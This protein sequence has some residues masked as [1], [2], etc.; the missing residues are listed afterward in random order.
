MSKNNV[1]GFFDREGEEGRKYR[2][3]D[4]MLK[5]SENYSENALSGKRLYSVLGGIGIALVPVLV[6]II[7]QKFEPMGIIFIVFGI[8]AAVLGYKLQSS[9]YQPQLDRVKMLIAADGIDAVYEDLLSAR[10]LERSTVMLGSRYVFVEGVGMARLKDIREVYLKRGGRYSGSSHTEIKAD[11]I[12]ESGTC[13][14]RLE[15][16]DRFGGQSAGSRLSYYRDTIYQA[17][18]I[19]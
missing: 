15:R 7:F 19:Q 1:L 6:W 13:S 16:S 3:V 10:C 18:I 2:T 8:T 4:N 17:K 12:D 14:L 11:V 5:L 9:H